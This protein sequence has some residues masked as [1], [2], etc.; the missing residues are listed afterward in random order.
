[1]VKSKEH[2]F[3]KTLETKTEMMERKSQEKQ[4]KWELLREDEKRKAA[5]EE[6]RASVDEKRTMVE[7]IAEE[8]KTMMNG[9]IH[10]MHAYTRE[11][12]EL[13][14]MEILQAEVSW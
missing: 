9:Y 1:M 6:R 7:L 10:H 12:W 14:R 2:F 5:A 11:W 13:M 3:N 4:A 8:N